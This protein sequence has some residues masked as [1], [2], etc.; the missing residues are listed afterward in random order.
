[1]DEREADGQAFRG[2]VHTKLPLQQ[3]HAF[4][5]AGE[6]AGPSVH[7]HHGQA[8]RPLQ[9]VEMVTERAVGCTEA[10]LEFTVAQTGMVLKG[11]QN[12][13]SERVGCVV[14]GTRARDATHGEAEGACCG[15]CTA[16]EARQSRRADREAGGNPRALSHPLLKERHRGKQRPILSEG[17]L[18][19]CPQRVVRR[20]PERIL[21]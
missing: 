16:A 17:S 12:S 7:V 11:A 21:R 5:G 13:P 2:P 8:R 15:Q 6:V 1:M 10:L 9:D 3:F 18:H 20:A 4:G 19:L 14:N